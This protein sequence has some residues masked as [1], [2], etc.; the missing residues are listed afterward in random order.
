MVPEPLG[1]VCVPLVSTL[2]RSVNERTSSSDQGLTVIL[3]V[4][5]LSCPL[6]ALWT[7]VR[8]EEL[9]AASHNS[10]TQLT[11][12]G[13]LE[14]GADFSMEF[15]VVVVVVVAVACTWTCASCPGKSRL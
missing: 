1:S 11:L 5:F 2:H 14:A 7:N 12:D 3:T 6:P 15:S 13:V 4:T 8:W 10:K 9:Q